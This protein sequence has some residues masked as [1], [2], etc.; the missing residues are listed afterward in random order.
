[1]KE[2]RTYAVTIRKSG[3]RYER[4]IIVRSCVSPMAACRVAHLTKTRP[5]ET[6]ILAY[7]GRALTQ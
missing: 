5:G 7:A 3:S 2:L 4:R 1:M 6:A